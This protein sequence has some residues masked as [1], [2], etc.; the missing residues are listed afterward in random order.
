M[1]KIV[2]FLVIGSGIAGLSYALKV[3]KYGKVCLV[4][5]NCLEDGATIYAQGGIASVTYQPDSYEKHIQDTLVA[6]CFLNREEVVRTVVSEGPERVKELIQWGTHF[7]TDGDGKFDLAK[8]GGHTEYRV[9]H[10]KDNT[11]REIQNALIQQVKQNSNIEVLNNHFAI[12]LITQHHLGKLVKRIYNDIECYGA[13]VQNRETHEIITILSKTT[14]LATGGAGNI[15]QNTTNPSVAT[16]DGVAMVY[17]AKGIIDDM[18]F[19][20]FHP[21]ALYHPIDRPSFLITEAL[22]GHGAILKDCNGNEFMHKYD[23]RGSLA[24]RDIV[25]R[26]IDNEM[27]LSGDDF[28]YLDATMINADEL[29]EKFPNIYKKCE[30]YGIDISKEYIPVTPA[31]HYMCGGIA[32][33]IHGKSSIKFLYAAG[34]VAAT[35]LH[36]ANRLASNSLLES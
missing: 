24:P 23:K 13:Y 32:T 14:L 25:A 7:D 21:T 5:K 3:S 2:D 36:G 10:S 35:G 31:A 15:Y 9:L 16:G 8:E 34:E 12:D 28:V 26:A 30:E 1:Q 22:R 18:E 29:K 4:T 20:Q 33:D 19:F 27:K 6:G 17:R 11:G